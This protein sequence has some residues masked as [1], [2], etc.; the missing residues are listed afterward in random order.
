MTPGGSLPPLKTV[1][2]AL[3]A[4]TERLAHECDR[5][6]MTPPAWDEFHW[7]IARAV[8]TMQGVSPLLSRSLRWQAPQAWRQFLNEQWQHTFDRQQSITRLMS[9]IDVRASNA[10][11]AIL[12]LK[13]A[14]LHDLGIYSPGAR[15]MAD[16]DL[17]VRNADAGATSALLQALGYGETTRRRREQV[18]EL[19]GAHAPA[20]FGENAAN[21]IKIELH[22]RIAESLPVRESSI[23][24]LL[25]PRTIRP[26]LHCYESSGALMT[27]LLLHAAGNM[28]TRSMRLIQLHDIA[29]L[30]R[31]LS[32]EEWECVLRQEGPARTWWAFPPLV[33][34]ARYF[35]A[36]IPSRVLARAAAVC[37]RV[38]RHVSRRQRLSDV[39]LSHLWIEFCPGIEWCS[40]PL[41]VLRYLQDRLFPSPETRAEAKTGEATQAWASNNAWSKLPRSRRVLRWLV[42]R[43]PRVATMWSVRAAWEQCGMAAMHTAGAGS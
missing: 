32:I 8:A 18:F 41:Q 4:T 5:P 23:T 17:L 39:S 27:H 43:P 3:R 2:R 15:P 38:L 9:R 6:T 22:T 14:A 24:E 1:E 30:S 31:R 12:A 10:G 35:P 13:G 11:I 40:S 19:A 29:A 28:R 34:T 36:S 16:L 37:P 33:L 7:C 42:S 21:A 25:L 20:P 26:G